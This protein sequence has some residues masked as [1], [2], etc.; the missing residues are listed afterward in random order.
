M[1]LGRDPA[2]IRRSVHVFWAPADD[3]AELADRAMGYGEAG[4]DVVIFSMRPPYDVN[5][6]EPLADALATVAST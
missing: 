3:P 4:I 1:A 5:R 2:E 6:V